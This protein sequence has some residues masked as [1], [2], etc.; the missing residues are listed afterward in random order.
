MKTPVLSLKNIKFKY[1]SG[2]NVEIE[3]LDILPEETI[4]IIGPN[5]AGKTTLL[6]IIG[7]LE[8]PRAPYGSGEIA[9]LGEK[10]SGNTDILSIRRQISFVFQ[11]SVLYNRSVFENVA[12]GFRIRKYP[13][14]DIEFKVNE[15]LEKLNIKN[16]ANR[17]NFELSGGEAQ[18]VCLARCLCLEP[19]LFLLDEPF[20]KL[21]FKTRESIILDLKGILKENKLSTIFVTQDKIEALKLC[22]RLLV[23]NH[24]R[25]VQEGA[26]IDVLRKPNSKF[27]AE[28]LGMENIFPAKIY[29]KDGLTLADIGPLTL[30]VSPHIEGNAYI[31]IRP[32]D[33]LIS[34]DKF[35]SS[36]RNSLCGKITNILDLADLIHVKIDAGVEFVSYITRQS[37]E[38][39]E[40]KKDMQVYITFKASAVNVIQF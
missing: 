32:E 25:I 28:F 5:G 3:N 33:I 38:E 35:S 24:G 4:G 20:S 10:I 15:W 22:D 40:L 9:F 31:S 12:I 14:K 8:K 18:R 37:L 17:R 30:T 2:T 16:L 23:M 1:E 11:N 36:A 21:D 34:K 26:P 39:M 13:K 27:V 29:R 6:K 7:F 19:K